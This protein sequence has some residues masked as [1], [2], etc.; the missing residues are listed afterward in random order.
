MAI[1]EAKL[2]FKDIDYFGWFDEKY[3]NWDCLKEFR[4]K[5]PEYAQILEQANPPIDSYKIKCNKI[6]W[7]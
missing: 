5:W 2:E 7:G 3:Y 4:A 6:K 1:A